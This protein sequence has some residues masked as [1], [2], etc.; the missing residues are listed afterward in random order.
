MFVDTFE[1]FKE[2][3]LTVWIGPVMYPGKLIEIDYSDN[4]LVI[5]SHQY[6]GQMFI[7]NA[8]AVTA[9][10]YDANID[11]VEKFELAK[12]A[13]EEQQRKAQ[14]DYLRAAQAIEEGGTEQ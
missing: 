8:T 5:E 10:S 13:A 4:S 7:V 6:K 11:T 9:I 3:L 1:Q 2:K 14:E 12:K